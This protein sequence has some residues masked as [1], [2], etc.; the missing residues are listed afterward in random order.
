MIDRNQ[1]LAAIRGD[2]A[3]KILESE[4]WRDAWK[5]YSDKLVSE[6]KACKS[7]DVDRLQ[8][9]K[10]L[11]LAGEAAKSHLEYLLT[12]GEFAKKDLEFKTKQTRIQRIL[13]AVK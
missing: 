1:E 6:W 2:K 4:E 3:R 8:Q 13:N 12:N 5:V 10:M 9:I 11:Q 7:D